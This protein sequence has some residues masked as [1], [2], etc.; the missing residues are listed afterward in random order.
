MR[1]FL[2][3]SLSLIVTSTVSWFS[4]MISVVSWSVLPIRV[5]NIFAFLG[6]LG[7]C[8]QIRGHSHNEEV[9]QVD[10]KEDSQSTEDH[11]H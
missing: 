2:P 9:T 6:L 5:V 10:H 7:T 3:N 11:H 4:A 8:R 1:K